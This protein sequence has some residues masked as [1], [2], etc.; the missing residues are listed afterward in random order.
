MKI[1]IVKYLYWVECYTIR[2]VAIIA[3]CSEDYVRKI[4]RGDRGKEIAA[5]Y[6]GMTENMVERKQVID[7]VMSLRGAYIV[8]AAQKYNYISLLAY[9]GFGV[10]EIR[11]IYPTDKNSFIGVAALRSGQ[12]WRNFDSNE[13]GIDEEMFRNTFIEPKEEQ[14][15]EKEKEQAAQQEL[16]EWKRKQRRERKI[17]SKNCKK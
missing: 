10:D 16:A 11:T 17:A 15:A 12:A 2:Q 3:G 8:D 1:A 13:I 9:M 14:V 4:V 7:R 5:N 6:E